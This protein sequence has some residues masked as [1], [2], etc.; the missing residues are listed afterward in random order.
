MRCLLGE[1]ES[2]VTV[3]GVYMSITDPRR[4]YAHRIPQKGKKDGLSFELE[5]MMLLT[6]DRSNITQIRR[7]V[8]SSQSW[9]TT[10]ARPWT[11]IFAGVDERL[12]THAV[13]MP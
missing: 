6:P 7:S 11:L 5:K 8:R 12:H 4:R 10:S 9:P 13:F 1:G 2:S 3:E